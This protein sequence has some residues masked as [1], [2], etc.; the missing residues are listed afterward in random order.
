MPFYSTSLC[1]PTYI[2]F[3][4]IIGYQD[5]CPSLILMCA[6]FEK[7]TLFSFRAMTSKPNSDD[8]FWSP[9]IQPRTKVLTHPVS[10]ITVQ[11]APDFNVEKKPFCLWCHWKVQHC[12][13]EGAGGVWR[14]GGFLA[15]KP[16][17]RNAVHDNFV[18][19]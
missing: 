3:T 2:I 10:L 5:A 12:A 15:L 16:K 4:R 8:I 1:L 18:L 6:N 14:R 17:K 11:P 19:F 13:P 9:R 7:N